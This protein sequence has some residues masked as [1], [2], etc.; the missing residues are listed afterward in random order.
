[1]PDCPSLAG[2]PFFN[3]K[4]AD[5]PALADVYKFRYCKDNNEACARWKV[6]S[7][8]GKEAVPADLFPNQVER[9]DEIISKKD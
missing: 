5:K 7:T 4:M 1:M 3:D 8:M 6:A 9:A 2:C